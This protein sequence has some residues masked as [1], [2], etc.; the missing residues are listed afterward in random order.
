M[1][2]VRRWMR[3]RTN[4]LTVLAYHG[5]D[6]AESFDRQLEFLKAECRVVSLAEVLQAAN[7]DLLPP[8]AVLITFDDGERTVLENA[9]PL[10]RDKGLPAVAFV[11][12]GMLDG[13]EPWWWE[14]ARWCLKHSQRGATAMENYRSVRRLSRLP[15]AERL[16]VIERLREESSAQCPRHSHLKSDE[17]ELL[18]RGG[19]DI[20][21]HT[22]T[23]PNLETCSPAKVHAEFEKSQKR[24]TDVLGSAPSTVAYPN[25]GHNNAVVREAAE[26]GFK[27][28]FL[29]DHDVCALPLRQPLRISRLR[30]SESASI[31][32][33]DL[34]LT[35]VHPKLLRMQE[36]LTAS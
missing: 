7:G 19:V 34:M 5:V 18:V 15:D 28:G 20:G 9:L 30:I 25:G 14:E 29:F 12:A 36:R 23:H 22:W 11:V 21:N 10:L 26:F 24:L 13:D 27:L 35:G 17:L 1:V 8:N 3:Q 2:F 32:R 6:D 4:H 31:E 33:L 16:L